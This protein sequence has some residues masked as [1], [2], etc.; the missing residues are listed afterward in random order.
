MKKLVSV[1]IPSYNHE[2]YI[3]DCVMS[4]LNQTY[5]NLEVF[6][7]DDCSTDNSFAIL[8]K[9]RDK[10]LK[11][12]RSKKNK[13]TVRT[14][15]EIT[16]KCNG[17]YVAI[18]GSDDLWEKDKIEKQVD[19]LD[20]HNDV[21]AVFTSAE[22]IDENG[23]L[24]EDDCYFSHEVFKNDNISNGKRMRLFFENGNHL[25][26]SSS[27]IRMNVI[28]KIGLYD[29]TFRQ[30]HDY[31]YWVRLINEFNIYI[32]DDKLVKYRRFKNFEN[33]LS[34]NSSKSVI[35]VVNENNA[36]INWMF[37]NIKNDLFID[38]FSDLFINKN[39]K[40]FEELLCE[41]Y[42]ILLK[43]NIIGIN[44][45]QIAFSLI[46]NYIDKEKLFNLFEKKYNYSLFDFYNDTGKAYDVFNFDVVDGSDC[47]TGKSIIN[48]LNTIKDQ[49][50]IIDGLN[51]DVH[52]L[53]YNINMLKASFSW[54]ITKPLRI[55]K[56][57]IRNE[58]N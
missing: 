34:N 55:I 22:I 24:Y 19:Y 53:E 35:R 20:K 56:G 26:H 37:N 31:E 2:K 13:G 10:R 8:K 48:N 16:K 1:I 23:N 43:Y 40:S 27:L 33:N 25:C 6:V 51:N 54:K 47:Y 14:I 39:S 44:N 4:V 49:Q 17:A 42:F 52:M 11:V 32:M 57:M 12:F 38:G 41:K 5:K 45:R 9:I 36:I 7:M 3:C 30:L 29:I 15:K 46:F 18:I 21:G 58:K 28:E 50:E